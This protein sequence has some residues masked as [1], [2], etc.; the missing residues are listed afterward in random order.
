MM[1][2]RMAAIPPLTLLLQHC[3]ILSCL[4]QLHF[5]ERDALM[6]LSGE[7]ADNGRGVL[8]CGAY[9]HDNAGDEA[10]LDAII[11]QMRALD[12][13]MPVTVLSRQP[14][15]T[16]ERYGVSA[17]HSFDVPGLLRAMRASKLFVSG[18]GSLIQDV[19]S[20]R[21]LFYYLFTLWA[22]RRQGCRVI[23]YGCGVGPVT[24]PGDRSLAGRVIDR[25]V[26]VIT[27]RERSS[28]EELR[29]WGVKKPEIL[30]AS[31]P[32]LSLPPA[33]GEEVDE[34]MRSLGLDPKGRYLGFCL[35]LWP[36]FQEKAACFA[37]AANMAYER[38]GLEPVF[39]P[40]NLREDL[41]AEALVREGLTAPCHTVDVPL[42]APLVMGLCARMSAMVALRLHGLI[43]AAGRGVP[44]VGVSYDPKVT[45][46]MDYIGQELCVELPD[47]T[48]ELLCSLTEKAVALEAERERLA[49]HAA[50]LRALNRISIEAAER[51]LK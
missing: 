30:L 50:R 49:E 11:R 22:A 21:S 48:P 38:F 3:I 6:R 17:L 31:D 29:A 20:R 8:L 9:G 28:E 18:G 5:A 33:P 32:A 42:P 1:M 4:L 45:A 46:F 15:R 25:N 16:A 35:R 23:M 7:K 10:I 27:L 26:D 12:P 2:R 44:L 41:A 40:I 47:L 24:K 14:A 51:L 39:L 34:V 43:F 13:D 19:T 37:A 36:G